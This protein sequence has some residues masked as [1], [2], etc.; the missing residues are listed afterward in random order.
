MS[1]FTLPVHAIKGRGSATAMPHRFHADAREPFDDG[2][3]T[4]EAVVRTESAARTEVV[5]EDAKSAISRNES[6]DIHFDYGLNPYRGCEHGCIYCYA[7]PTHSYLNL[8]PG[9]D[10]E[11]RIIAKPNL[12]Q[13][14]A[15]ELG[16]RS[17]VPRQI[18][19]GSA[20]DAYQ[21][22][23]RRLRITRSLIE[24]LQRC[25]HPLAIVTKGS[26]VERD[27]DLLAPMAAHGLVAVYVTITTLDSELAR[28]LEPRA[29]SPERRLRT[30]RT[31]AEAGVP[32]GVSVA[33]QIPFINEDLEQVLGASAAAGAQR[34]F[35]AVLRLPWEVNPLFQQW[36][37]LHYPLR[38]ERV[39]A[40]VREMRGGRDYDSDFATRMKGQGVWAELLRQ[41]FEKTCA[42]LGLNRERLPLDVTQFRPALLAGQGSL[43]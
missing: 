34:A 8:S 9:L 27:L 3:G 19:I 31:L 20:T 7:R 43:F 15:G 37:A 22:I 24:L 1:H 30:I 41:R 14:L 29:A 26:G 11:T 12:A 38:A 18:V 33:P 32:V 10:F 39:M 25:H 36:L 2:W 42:R 40:R 35:Y 23:E 17:Y 6:P 16:R 5:L 28:K 21:P 13:R 4:A